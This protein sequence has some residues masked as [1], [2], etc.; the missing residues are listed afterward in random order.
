MMLVLWPVLAQGADAVSYYMPDS[1]GHR[2]NVLVVN[3]R[4]GKYLR[5]DPNAS[6]SDNLPDC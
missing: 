1:Y 6:C 5:T 4:T 2:A 3:G